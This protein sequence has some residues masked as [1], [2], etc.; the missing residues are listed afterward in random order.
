MPTAC[1][2]ARASLSA[3]KAHIA[4]APLANSK[5]RSERDQVEK[6]LMLTDN[7]A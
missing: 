5:L 2:P 7:V 4:A 3:Q 1:S 6:L